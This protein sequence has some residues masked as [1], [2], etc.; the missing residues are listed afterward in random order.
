M[1][2][3]RACVE[4]RSV[5][6]TSI[7]ATALDRTRLRLCYHPSPAIDNTPTRNQSSKLQQLDS[8]L[9]SIDDGL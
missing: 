1:V 5:E 9:S 2:V 4:A 3:R 8:I 6:Y 7:Q